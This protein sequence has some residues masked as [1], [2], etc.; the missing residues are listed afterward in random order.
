MSSVSV[1]NI[2]SSLKGFSRLAALSATLDRY[3][4]EQVALDFAGCTWFEANMCAPLGAVLKSTPNTVTIRNLRPE[5]QGILSKNRFLNNYGF[6]PQRDTNDT[7]MPYQQFSVR[8]NLLVPHYL[9]EYLSGKG[10]PIMSQALSRSFKESTLELCNNAKDHAESEIGIFVCGQ[11]FPRKQRL[12]FCIA[13]AGIGIRRRILKDLRKKMTSEQAIQWALADGNTTRQGRSPGGLGLNLIREFIV[14]N[15]GHIQIVS[16]D[17]YWELS[18]KG[19]TLKRLDASFP[20]TV[21]N[22]E[23]NTADRSSYRLTSESRK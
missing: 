2:N 3:F 20:G 4:L 11:Y 17:G 14:M 10:L 5:I 18:P 6:P 15:Q 13:D 19:E 8:D 9:N 22:I 12:D 16:D 23:I 21:I 7:V 1:G